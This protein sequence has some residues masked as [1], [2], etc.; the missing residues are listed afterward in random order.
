[1]WKEHFKNLL[2]NLP[3][4]TNKPFQKIINGQ[5]DIKLRQFTEEELS[6]VLKKLLTGKLQALRK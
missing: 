1:M 4:I 3:E 6:T 2:R 5:Q